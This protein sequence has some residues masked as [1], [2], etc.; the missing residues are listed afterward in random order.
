MGYMI[1][2]GDQNWVSVS[3]TMKQLGEGGRPSDWYKHLVLQE[4]VFSLLS[5]LVLISLNVR[6]K[7]KNCAL[8][9][10]LLLEK[11]DIPTRKRGEKT[12]SS[13]TPA[14]RIVNQLAQERI[15][16]LKIILGEVVFTYF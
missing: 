14:Q 6:F 8:Q 12:D 15:A 4:H 9:Y 1:R 13:E 11:A 2:N 10:N 16:E 3:R 5:C 7:D